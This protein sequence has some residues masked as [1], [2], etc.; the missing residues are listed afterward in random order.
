M[1]DLTL[2][3]VREL[4]E[5][6]ELA[7]FRTRFLPADDPGLVAYLDGNSLGRPPAALVERMTGFL[8]EQWGTRLIRG[9][10]DGWLDL[11]LRLGD[12][13]GEI[14][15]GAAPGQVALADS[16]TVCLYKLLR[17]ALT[18]RPERRGIVTDTENFPTDRYLVEGIAAERGS[19]VRWIKSDPDAG[20]TPAQ[21]AEVVDEDT[22]VV[23]LSHVAYQSAH[24][25]DLPAI[26]RIAHDA[27]ALVV[28]DLCHSVGSVALE[29][30]R[31]GVDFA[32]GCTYKYLNA[33]PGAPAFLYARAEHQHLTQPVQGWLGREDA[34][35]M[36]PGYEP[37]A[38]IRRFLSGTPPIPSLLGVEAGLDL[39]AEA[40]IA[41]V[42]RKSIALTELAI[43]LADE[44]LAELGLLLGSP[45]EPSRRGG[46][47]T[48]RRADARDLSAA[49]I[50]AGVLVDFR[51]PDGIRLGL[52]PLTTSFEELWRAM[53]V[54]RRL[55]G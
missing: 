14:A 54:I 15:L 25:A 17:T 12:R 39:V 41:R 26:T 24:L 11:P 7:E 51:A 21:V 22:A 19:T 5:A 33:G 40:G 35:A 2:R 50:E 34:F 38:G 37:A 10:E 36:A 6:D 20:V 47:V 32:A 46:H 42:R 28:W 48:L 55:A 49:L 45:R 8:R 9:W 4:D 16:T 23:T 29:L 53:E 44:W 30:D 43:R 18:A 31:D 27:G 52:S 13:L 3:A 1:S